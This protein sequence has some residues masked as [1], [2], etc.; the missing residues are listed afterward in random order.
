M[1]WQ[2][3]HLEVTAVSECLF[4]DVCVYVAVCLL[5]FVFWVY[6]QC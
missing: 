1:Q 5:S 3:T 2:T 4:T 6:Q